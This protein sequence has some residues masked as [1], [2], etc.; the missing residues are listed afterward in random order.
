M[1]H[2]SRDALS[3]LW[4]GLSA[5][6]RKTF[7]VTAWTGDKGYVRKDGTLR[8]PRLGDAERFGVAGLCRA[9][10]VTHGDNGWHLHA[11]VLVVTT[12][13][14]GIGLR[15]DYN[16][17]LRK[18]L[19]HDGATPDVLVDREWLGSAA[20]S[21]TVWRRWA[22]GLEKAGL[23]APTSIGVDLRLINDGGE[24]V[25]GRYLSKATYDAAKK[26][27]TEIAAGSITKQGKG[28]EKNESR[29]RTPF[30]ILRSLAAGEQRRWKLI[31]DA[32]VV[33]VVADREG[34]HLA[35]RLTG[36]VKT[37][38]PPGDWRLWAEYESAS[39]GRAQL[40]WS[41]TRRDDES[42]RQRLWNVVLASRGDSAERSNEELADERQE[43]EVIVTISR[44]G[45]KSM[46]R[47][48]AW[49]AELLD[50]VEANTSAAYGW[51][52]DREIELIEPA[53]SS[54]AR[55]RAA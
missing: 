19:G 53:H 12:N 22:K 48:P 15:D 10:E 8:P 37:I 2:H 17:V 46:L 52:R 32:R 14:L 5:A 20:F 55:A 41:R 31:V 1:R 29:N 6:W 24:E 44:N 49:L 43:G 42:H 54:D 30:E 26:A 34:V 50:L 28:N 25:V 45:W 47:S 23:E 18:A 7:G 27:G 13:G 39:S 16:E 35:E 51:L 3:E 4:S 9:V 11:H 36:E 33:A 40:V 21:W 38:R